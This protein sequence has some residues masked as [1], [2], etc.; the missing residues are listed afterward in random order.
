MELKEYEHMHQL[1]QSFWWYRALH[2]ATLQ[3]VLTMALPEG[4]RVLDAGCGTGGL[5]AHLQKALPDLHYTGLEYYGQAASYSREK[6]NL[7]II[8]GSVNQLPFC[9]N[10]FDLV[11][12]NDVLYHLN[13]EPLA[14]VQEYRRVL[15]PGGQLLINIAAFNWMTSA[16]DTHVHTRERYT[17]SSCRTL[18]K[19][20]GFI[21]NDCHYWNSLLFPLMVLHRLTAGKTRKDSDVETLAPWLDNLLFTIMRFEQGL[22]SLKLYFPFGG[23]VWARATKPA[24]A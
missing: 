10:Y 15:K 9:D 1:E 22:A 12:C 2:A 13:V 20:G 17:R 19:D 6:T 23:S 8:N 5:L 18:L 24:Q 11:I 7:D 21:V 14:A 16:H 3:R 4:A